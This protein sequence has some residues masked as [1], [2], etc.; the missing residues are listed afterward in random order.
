MVTHPEIAVI[1]ARLT[2]EFSTHPLALSSKTR[3][4]YLRSDIPYKSQISPAHGRFGI[5]L[6][7]YRSSME[8]LHYGGNGPQGRNLVTKKKLCDR[9]ERVK[10][11]SQSQEDDKHNK[12][13]TSPPEKCLSVHTPDHG[14]KGPQGRNLVT[15]RKLVFHSLGLIEQ[16]GYMQAILQAKPQR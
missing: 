11:N 4:W 15:K 16:G 1:R 13:P 2:M 3:C 7:C 12:T 9:S 5:C 8:S 6:G 10:W 14:R